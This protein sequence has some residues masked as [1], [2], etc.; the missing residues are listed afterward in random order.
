MNIIYSIAEIIII[1]IVLLSYPLK[2]EK[3]T[4]NKGQ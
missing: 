3:Y 2:F 1:V 4:H